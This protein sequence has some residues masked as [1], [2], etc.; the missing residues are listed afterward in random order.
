MRKGTKRR[1]SGPQ[2]WMKRLDELRLLV[3][4]PVENV[5][6]VD[7]RMAKI[8]KEYCREDILYFAAECINDL[9]QDRWCLMRDRFEWT[10]ENITRLEAANE[11]LKTALCEMRRQTIETYETAKERGQN[12]SI[13]VEGTLWVE[14]MT[15]EEWEQ[16]EDMQEALF[17]VM[18]ST[19]YGGFY[20][21]SISIP[22]RLQ[23]NAQVTDTPDTYDSEN[24]VLYLDDSIGNW[25]E[26][27][28][29]DKTEN[30]HLVYAIHN[31]YE[32]CHW[33]LQ[34][35]LGIK[36][37]KAKIEVEYEGLLAP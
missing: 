28:P 26:L 37:Y 29:R 19:T 1:Q 10:A 2:K 3:A 14:D 18:A 33:S 22:F 13:Y 36:S 15:F 12:Q 7:R 11:R 30:L 27:M 32:H 31:L 34:D 21:N 16:N 17:D 25:D 24:Q 5:R 9:K 4:K 35:I 8:Y 6:Q 20:A 23:Y